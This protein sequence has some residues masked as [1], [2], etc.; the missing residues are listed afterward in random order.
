VLRA[1][2]IATG[3]VLFA[4]ATPAFAANARPDAG[5]GFFP[6][7]PVSGQTVRFVS[8]ACDPDGTLAE[9]RWD[10]DGD[11]SFDDATGSNAFTSFSGGLHPVR[12]RVTDRRGLTATR[13]R[14]VD[15]EPGSPD[16]VLPQPFNP[17]L[18]SPFPFVRLSGSVSGPRTRINVLSVRAPVCS[19]VTVL[20]RGEGCP[21]RRH[22]KLA[23]RRP[24]RFRAIRRLLAGATIRVLVSKRD[25][26]GKYTR[27]RTR[28]NK[29]PKRVDRCLRFG[30][31][32]GSPCPEE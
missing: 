4:C 9:Q 26:I 3:G 1:L 21:W 6:R 14:V 28:A 2:A 18:L 11:G 23:G 29:A 19:R 30:A 17:P 20:C 5:F 31:T 16:Y 25:R 12:L 27:F 32:R 7:D 10:L 24:T 13:A 22:T 15:V 8:Y